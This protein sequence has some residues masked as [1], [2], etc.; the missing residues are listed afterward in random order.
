MKEAYFWF[1]FVKYWN[2]SFSN[3]SFQRDRNDYTMYIFHN[4]PI[5]KIILWHQS[6]RQRSTHDGGFTRCKARRVTI[7]RLSSRKLLGYRCVTLRKTKTNTP[8]AL[9]MN[10]KVHINH[11]TDREVQ[12]SEHRAPSMHMKNKNEAALIYHSGLPSLSLHS[13]LSRSSSTW[14]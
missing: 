3:V 9:T 13:G 2:T 14:R 10:T 11:K 7:Q 5:D 6:V 12:K 1:Q 4:F 8:L